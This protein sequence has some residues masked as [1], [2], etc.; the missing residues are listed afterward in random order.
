MIP[1]FSLKGTH[2]KHLRREFNH[3]HC[4]SHNFFLATALKKGDS[5]KKRKTFEY[6]CILINTKA[7]R[8]TGEPGWFSGHQ[9]CTHLCDPGSTLGLEVVCG[10]S[11]SR[12]QSDSEGFSPGNPV[13]LPPQNQLPVYSIRLWCCAPRSYMGHVQGPSV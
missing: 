9:P 5:C 2:H 3:G 6:M 10:L 11:F 4:L 7:F 1:A 12:S 8:Y 13:F